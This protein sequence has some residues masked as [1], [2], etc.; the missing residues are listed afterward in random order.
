MTN[1]SN[2]FDPIFEFN[3]QVIQLASTDDAF[4]QSLLNNPKAAIENSFPEI[5]EA[6]LNFVVNVADS[7]TLYLTIPGSFDT[8]ELTDEQLA[9][10]SGGVAFIGGMAAAA[11]AIKAAVAAITVK[12]VVGAV[13]G[14]VGF[15]AS[16]IAIDDKVKKG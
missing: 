16:V 3:S 15:A 4:R 7:N 6:N 10:V 14:G 2:A 12:T 1:S 8:E 13:V 11:V 9:G 5:K